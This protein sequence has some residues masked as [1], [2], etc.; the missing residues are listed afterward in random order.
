M[1]A[2]NYIYCYYYQWEDGGAVRPLQL[3]QTSQLGTEFNI[4]YTFIRSFISHTLAWARADHVIRHKH[5]YHKANL[6]GR[7]RAQQCQYLT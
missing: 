3:L 5:G 2:C 4:I 7:R 1:V 6:C